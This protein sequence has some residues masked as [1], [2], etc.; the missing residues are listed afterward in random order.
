M[1]KRWVPIA[2]NS[3]PTIPRYEPTLHMQILSQQKVFYRR[4]NFLLT[5]PRYGL[6]SL[7]A[8]PVPLTFSPY[9]I[10]I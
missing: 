1:W 10:L 9:F 3:G 4:L 5:I 6:H 8:K 7:Y 2:F